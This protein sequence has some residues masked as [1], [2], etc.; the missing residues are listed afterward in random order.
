LFEKKEKIKKNGE[1]FVN[2]PLSA[3]LTGFI[4]SIH[5][6]KVCQGTY[7]IINFLDSLPEQH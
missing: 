3:I 1:I 2:L 4:H 5:V 6:G 7:P